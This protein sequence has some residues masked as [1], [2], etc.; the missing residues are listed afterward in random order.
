VTGWPILY[1]LFLIL[2]SSAQVANPVYATQQ[3]QKDR[4][5]NKQ[6]KAIKSFLIFLS[7]PFQRSVTSRKMLLH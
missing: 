1:L 7:P 3:P 6:S 4:F 5:N 2:C